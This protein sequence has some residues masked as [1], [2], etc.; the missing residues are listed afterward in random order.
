MWTLFFSGDMH[1]LHHLESS[2]RI[3]EFNN[4]NITNNSRFVCEN[5]MLL[6]DD[7]VECAGSRSDLVDSSP[8]CDSDYFSKASLKAK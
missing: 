1:S 7:M 4:A 2:P 8:F 6:P 5:E 3:V